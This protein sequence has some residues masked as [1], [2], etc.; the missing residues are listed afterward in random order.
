MV[1]PVDYFPRRRVVNA[2]SGDA[3]KDIAPE[4]LR[5]A[6]FPSDVRSDTPPFPFKLTLKKLLTFDTPHKI[7]NAFNVQTS[8]L[9][10]CFSSV[11]PE[12]YYVHSVKNHNKSSKE[13]S[14]FGS[15]EHSHASGR[16]RL[17]RDPYLD[18]IELAEQLE[19]ERSFFV[20][21]SKEGSVV[22]GREGG[23]IRHRNDKV[24]EPSIEPELGL[25]INVS[26]GGA[27]PDLAAVP[28]YRELVRLLR[29]PGLESIPLDHFSSHVIAL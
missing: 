26:S 2:S 22:Q 3:K 25:G 4:Y 16:K 13:M 10:N 28:S 23:S 18:D 11:S 12:Y 6:T 1:G 14:D 24:P 29:T 5:E 15:D 8:F 27:I 21:H 19:L 7:E 20:P 17:W 9:V